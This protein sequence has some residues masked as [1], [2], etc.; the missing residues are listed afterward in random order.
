MK[1]TPSTDYGV[2]GTGFTPT[3]SGGLSRNQIVAVSIMA[4]VCIVL[5]LGYAYEIDLFRSGKWLY[6]IGG[7]RNDGAL[8][9]LALIPGTAA[10]IHHILTRSSQQAYA[11]SEAERY[12]QIFQSMSTA[13]VT[14]AASP[15]ARERTTRERSI[16]SS[17][18]AA[19][20]L[21]TTFML[22]AAFMDLYAFKDA[23]EGIKGLIAAGAGA[24]VSVL[25]YMTGRMY[26]NALSSRFVSASAL[27]SAFSVAIGFAAGTI[28]ATDLLPSGKTPWVALFL[29][30]LFHN[31]A[32]D[33]IRSRADAWFGAPKAENEELPLD[34][35]QGIDDTTVD[36]LREY[37]IA[38]IQQL[39]ESN[40]TSVSNRALI[41]LETL[42][43]WIDQAILI[44]NIQRK[45]AATRLLG[46][47]TATDLTRVWIRAGNGDP[48]A[49]DLLKTLAQKTELNDAGLDQLARKLANNITVRVVY[50]FRNGLDLFYVAIP[51]PPALV[52][53]P[54][55]QAA[56]PPPP[57]PPP[58]A[59]GAGA[60][61]PSPPSSPT[62]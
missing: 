41:P 58:A 29:V 5:P 59:P 1:G 50:L 55:Q 36:L 40:A 14:S 11:T 9:L 20:L 51:Q 22:V 4:A 32:Y 23:S 25:Y 3:V 35:I 10:V 31:V 2:T 12:D 15:T 30:G 62:S 56:P 37:G 39:A 28:G 43:D 8:Y 17:S 24:Y 47:R 18:T 6:Y 53:P 49:K 48:L 54:Q 34:T 45:V 60:P 42:C 13:G 61:P 33:A 19:L 27:K 57:P 16:L 7:L 52:P 26:A 21:T 38:T 46:V 44:V